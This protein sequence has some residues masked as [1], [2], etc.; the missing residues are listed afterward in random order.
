[1]PRSLDMLGNT[2]P[3]TPTGGGGIA[4]NAYQQFNTALLGLMK[5]HQSLGTKPFVQQSLNAQ[6]AQANRVS[7][8]TPDSL[9]GAAPTVQSGV[10]SASAAAINPTIQG[11]ENSAQT[12]GEQLNSFGNLI[13]FARQINQDY[14]QAQERAQERAF[15]QIM[16]MIQNYGGGAFKGLAEEEL[17]GLEKTAGLPT[18]F[19]KR[20][21]GMKTLSEQIT[22]YQQATLDLDKQQFKEGQRQFDEGRKTSPYQ[23]AALAEEKRQFDVK[24]PVAPVTPTG[25]SSTAAPSGYPTSNLQPGATGHEVQKLQDWLVANGYMTQEEV[26]TGYGKYG[27]RTTAA[28]AK[29]QQQYGVDNSTGV[30]YWG[31]RTISALGGQ[32]ASGGGAPNDPS[33]WTYVP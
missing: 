23:E 18:G 15:N 33:Y 13:N 4:P 16:S 9:I 8:Q 22:P 1:M 2:S 17:K 21:A 12:F 31:P 26:S 32:G 30:G 14:S 6:E 25:S 20:A 10:R 29:V 7:A 24:N 3:P 27:P 19:L 28:V 5:E 11:A